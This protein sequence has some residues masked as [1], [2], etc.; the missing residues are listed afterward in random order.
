MS[1]WKIIR[2]DCSCCSVRVRERKKTSERSIYEYN[3]VKYIGRKA[4]SEAIGLSVHALKW[5][6]NNGSC[7][8][9]RG[10][11]PEQPN[12]EEQRLAQRF[13]AVMAQTMGV[14]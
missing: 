12:R 5:R 8:K 4:F 3:G 13:C 6:M 1:D 10:R 11:R 2:F 7:L 14:L 9:E